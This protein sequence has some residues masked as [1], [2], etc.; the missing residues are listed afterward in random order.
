MTCRQTT[1]GQETKEEKEMEDE[2]MDRSILE[3]CS[4]DSC[5]QINNATTAAT[6][7]ARRE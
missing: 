1:E 6:A 2:W 3:R 5:Q 4:G 7:S